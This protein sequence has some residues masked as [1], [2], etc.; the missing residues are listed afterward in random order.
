MNISDTDDFPNEGHEVVNFLIQRK[1]L[2]FP[3]INRMVVDYDIIDTPKG[4]HLNVV[5]NIY[6]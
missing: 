1:K 2:V 5:S 6:R 3:D 4:V